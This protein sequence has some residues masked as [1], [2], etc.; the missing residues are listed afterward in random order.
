MELAEHLT[1]ATPEVVLK[2]LARVSKPM[3]FEFLRLGCSPLY[4]LVLSGD[5]D[6]G[7]YIQDG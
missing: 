2:P 7:Y 3:V 5:Y 4:L 1:V 6:R